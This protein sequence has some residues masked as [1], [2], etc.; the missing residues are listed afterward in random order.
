MLNMQ[1]AQTDIDKIIFI[2]LSGLPKKVY[3]ATNK[4]KF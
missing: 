4:K 1:I 3:F 2:K